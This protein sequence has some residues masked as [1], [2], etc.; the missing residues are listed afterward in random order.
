M[1]KPGQNELISK[2]EDFADNFLRHSKHYLPHVA[3]FCLVSTFFEDGIRMWF[4]WSEQRD[5]IDTQWGCGYALATLFVLLNFAG[6]LVPC[7]MVLA[8]K[9]VE[10]AVGGLFGI[11]ILQ[12]GH[13]SIRP[14][15]QLFRPIEFSFETKTG[16]HDRAYRVWMFIFDPLILNKRV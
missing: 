10:I 8:R 9:K 13:F 12:V 16:K 15:F 7:F 6:Q 5:Y 11:I 4:Q 2:A 14:Q 3:R 1:S